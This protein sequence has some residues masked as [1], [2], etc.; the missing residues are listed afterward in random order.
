MESQIIANLRL[1]YT[2]N[3]LSEK[4]VSQNPIIQFENWFKEALKSEVKEP[5]AFVLSTVYNGKPRARVVLLK[6]FSEDGFVFFTNYNSAKGREISA[7][8]VGCMTFFWVDL[9]RQVRIEGEINKISEESSD[10]Y[11]WSRPISSQISAW[12]SEQSSVIPDRVFLDERLAFFEE[13][14]K[15][16]SPIPRPAHWGGYCIKPT[17]IEF[18]QGRPNRL[19][20]RI[21]YTQENEVWEI[22]RLSS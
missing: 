2:L 13:K 16:I 14:F 11:F 15:N 1:N 3:E 20:D 6:D 21:A 9:E 8:A 18:W 10:E 12:V 4:N 22:E 17:F 7:N 5:N 19:H